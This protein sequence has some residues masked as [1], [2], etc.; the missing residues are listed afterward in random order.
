[1]ID[2]TDVIVTVSSVGIQGPVGPAANVSGDFYP[3]SN[4]SG[5]ITSG[6]TG[7]FLDKNSVIS[8]KTQLAS[9][10][11]SSWVPF[12]VTLNNAPSSIV[13]SIQNDIDL[14]VYSLCIFGVN[15]SGF[16]V[17]FSDY[18]SNSGYSL[19]SQIKV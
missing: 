14:F 9:G 2:L 5:Y 4:P 8:I 19:N 12:G 13:C 6:Q 3:V 16:N 7:E 18:L 17:A 10:V 11:I 15:N 1:M